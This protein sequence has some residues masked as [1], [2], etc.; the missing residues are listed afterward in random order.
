MLFSKRK[1]NLLLWVTAVVSGLGI[2]VFGEIILLTSWRDCD[3]FM[4]HL[5]CEVLASVMVP[6]ILGFIYWLV[7]SEKFGH[8]ATTSDT[9]TLDEFNLASTISRFAAMMS[10]LPLSMLVD[11]VATAIWMVAVGRNCENSD[12]R[13]CPS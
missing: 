5:I 6:P 11:P 7:R 13:G 9:T 3:F 1:T 8:A 2:G 12:T 10:M 4:N